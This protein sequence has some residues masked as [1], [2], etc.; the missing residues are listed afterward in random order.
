[1][2]ISAP[3]AGIVQWS[4]YLSPFASRL[5][6][7]ILGSVFVIGVTL[8]IGQKIGHLHGIEVGASPVTESVLQMLGMYCQ[9]GKY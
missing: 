3:A 2:Y 9:Q 7:V 8:S 1:M 4:D 5:W 6:Y